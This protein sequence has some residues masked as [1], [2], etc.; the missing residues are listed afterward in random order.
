MGKCLRY[1]NAYIYTMD[2]QDF[3]TAVRYQIDNE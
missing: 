1:D 2:R 3:I